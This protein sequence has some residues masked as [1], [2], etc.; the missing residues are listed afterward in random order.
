MST[1]TEYRVTWDW[2]IGG[3]YLPQHEIITASNAKEAKAIVKARYIPRKTRNPF[4]LEAKRLKDVK[5]TY[6]ELAAAFRDHESKH[7]DDRHD[8]G[9]TGAIVFTPD[10]FTEEYSTASRTYLVSSQ[11]KAFMPNMGGYSIYGSALDGSDPLVR[12]DAYMA[13]EHGGENG[14]KVDYCYLLP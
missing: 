9:L 7:A 11:N 1:K 8:V 3:K 4:H 10:S 13:A 5:I 14:W 2:L 12:L 6:A